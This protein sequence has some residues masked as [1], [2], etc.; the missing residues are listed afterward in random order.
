LLDVQQASYE[1]IDSRNLGVARFTYDVMEESF[2]GVIATNGDPT[3]NDDNSVIGADVRLRNSHFRGER[4]LAL[5]AWALQSFSEDLDHDEAAF[6]ARIDYPNDRVNFS[7]GYEQLEENY[8][9]ALGFVNRVGIQRL[10]GHFRYRIRPEG[11]LRTV[12]NEVRFLAVTDSHGDLESAEVAWDWV[13]VE[14]Q[15]GD[16][17]TLTYKRRREDLER[18]F[19]ISE[20]VIL[21]PT[22]YAFDRVSALLTTTKARALSV[23]VLLGWGEFFSGNRLESRALIEWRPSKYLRVGIEYEQNAVRLPEGDFTTRLAVLRVDAAFN[24]DLAWTTIAQYD[25]IS[26]TLGIQSR[27]TWIIEPGDEIFLVYNQGFEASPRRFR[28]IISDVTFKVGY[29]FRF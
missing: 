2:I 10:D 14:S 3:S 1:D 25:N 20:G 8:R 6:G 19:E 27:V 21:A 4:V 18:P 22:S 17:L 13:K 12:D 15:A 9:P 29:T 16:A 26:D 7:L 28:P 11:Y 5:D 24:P 23:E